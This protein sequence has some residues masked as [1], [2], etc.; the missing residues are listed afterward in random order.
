M[1]CPNIFSVQDLL[2][3]VVEGEGHQTEK[4]SK[5]KISYSVQYR[6]KYTDTLCANIYRYS[7]SHNEENLPEEQHEEDHET[8]RWPSQT[9]S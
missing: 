3:K 7:S 1:R 9:E 4:Y 8:P 5:F 2:I 6:P